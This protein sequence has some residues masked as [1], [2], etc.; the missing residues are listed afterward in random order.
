MRPKILIDPHPFLESVHNSLQAQYDVE[1]LYLGSALQRYASKNSSAF[2]IS[3]K[4]KL[5]DDTFAGFPSWFTDFAATIE[6]FAGQSLK[7]QSAK[8]GPWI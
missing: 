7:E 6:R 5:N 1:F 2:H 4:L 8:Y 3:D